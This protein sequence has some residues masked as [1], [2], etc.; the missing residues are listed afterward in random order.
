MQYIELVYVLG[1]N[2]GEMGEETV[3]TALPSICFQVEPV[4]AE[5]GLKQCL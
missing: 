3:Q 4:K 5:M 2:R 1:G